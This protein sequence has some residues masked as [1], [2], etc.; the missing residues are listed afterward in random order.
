M[1]H[2]FI[3][4][5]GGAEPTRTILYPSHPG[6]YFGGSENRTLNQLDDGLFSRKEIDGPFLAR[7]NQLSAADPARLTLEELQLW[8]QHA[9]KVEHGT[10]EATLRFGE[11]LVEESNEFGESLLAFINNPSEENRHAA[12][13]EAGDVL[14][15]L[16]A[17]ISN[18]GVSIEYAIQNRLVFTAKGTLVR[19]DEGMRYPAWRDKA[20]EIGMSSLHP[21]T[22]GAIDELFEAGYVPEVST[23]MNLEPD[24][25]DPERVEEVYTQWKID[26]AFAYVLENEMSQHMQGNIVLDYNTM[27]HTIGEQAAYLFLRTIYTLRAITNA[28]FADIWPVNYAKVTGRVAS[29]L[30]DHSDGER[31]SEL[32]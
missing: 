24:F 14:W 13:S 18:S 30:I 6:N 3:N 23:A 21:V 22:V 5:D 16:S 31:P 8:G 10:V 9:W 15:S 2:L 17:G 28:T 26:T 4:R 12:I 1:N 29:G 27:R 20:I 19:T 11:K 32:Q 7:V 25:H